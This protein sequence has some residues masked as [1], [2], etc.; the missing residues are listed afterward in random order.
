MLRKRCAMARV[1]FSLRDKL[2]AEI[3]AEAKDK[4]TTRSAFIRAALEN[5][6]EHRRSQR[7]EEAK[8]RKMRAAARKIDV[9]AKKL[10]KWD[11]QETIRRARE[12]T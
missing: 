5:Y 7:E 12:T 6:I 10:G 2:L 1:N 8:R 3:D 9:L 4:R 11:P